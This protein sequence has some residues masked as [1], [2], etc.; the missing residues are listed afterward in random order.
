MQRAFRNTALLLL[1]AV[2][3]LSVTRDYWNELMRGNGQYYAGRLVY[4]NLKKERSDHLK[5]QNPPVTVLSCADSRVPPEL[6]FYKT[7]G[8][9]F[10]VRVAGNVADSFPVASIEYAIAPPQAYTKLIVVMG[11]QDCGAVKAAIAGGDAGS[12]DLNALVKRIRDNI[13][14]ERDLKKATEKNTIA[15]AEYLVSHSKIIHDAVCT[16][17]NPVLMKAAY[18]N[19]DGTVTELPLPRTLCAPS[20]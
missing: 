12:P 1:F 19:F 4:A 8:D 7:I 14:V 6:I 11:H 17:V 10:V 2:S 20:H 9:L 18:Y 3:A 5:T 13:G 15:S 16:Q